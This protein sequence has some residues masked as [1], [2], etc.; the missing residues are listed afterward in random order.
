MNGLILLIPFLLIRFGLLHMRSREA[1]TRAAF[2]APMKGN[3]RIAYF[4]YQISNAAIL[5]YSAFLKI[6]ASSSYLFYGG[7]IIYLI[8]FV[9]LVFSVID[10][11][12][13]QNSGINKNGIYKFSRNPM[14]VS[15]FIFL[16]GCAI[17]ASS[18]ILFGIILIFQISAHWIILA[19]EK[20]CIEKFDSE[21]LQYMSEVRRYI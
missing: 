2:F 7:L 9:L 13:P 19:E 20:W 12:N 18:W 17:I 16:V 3:E 14:Y 1:V 21:Y 15:Y 10:F 8:G 11:A 6:V 5:F 4:I